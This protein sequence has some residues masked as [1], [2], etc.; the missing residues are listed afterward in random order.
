MKKP[1]IYNPMNNYL[2]RAFNFGGKVRGIRL[3]MGIRLIDLAEKVGY[4]ISYMSQ[5]ENNKITPSIESLYK[6]STFFGQPMGYFF[7]EFNNHN[8]FVV[9]KSHQIGRAHV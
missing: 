7:E 8:D 2:T 1:E 4:S 9:K 6:L 5:L 3:K